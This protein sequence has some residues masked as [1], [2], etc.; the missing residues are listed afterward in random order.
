MIKG[1]LTILLIFWS[2]S[3]LFL[4]VF[5]IIQY[6]CGLVVMAHYHCLK[7]TEYWIINWLIFFMLDIITLKIIY[8]WIFRHFIKVESYGYTEKNNP[9]NKEPKNKSKSSFNDKK[10]TRRAP[11]THD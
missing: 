3:L 11:G 7:W 5:N 8:S 6:F 2:I 4:G 1:K 9:K 10:T